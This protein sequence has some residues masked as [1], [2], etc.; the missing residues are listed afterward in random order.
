MPILLIL[1]PDP[2]LPTMM[3]AAPQE[4]SQGFEAPKL[5]FI[6]LS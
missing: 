4:R 3:R 5:S 2:A 1:P 6:Y